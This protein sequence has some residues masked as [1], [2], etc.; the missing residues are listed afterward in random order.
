MNPK[1]PTA[2]VA[3]MLELLS[4]EPALAEAVAEVLVVVVADPQGAGALDAAE[5]R[6]A[7]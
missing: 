6:P 3:K 2:K 1:E 5:D 4:A 7:A